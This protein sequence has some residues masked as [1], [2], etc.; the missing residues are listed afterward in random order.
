M[1]SFIGNRFLIPLFLHE[2]ENFKF[3]RC[4]KRDDLA[5][6]CFVMLQAG[7]IPQRGVAR[8]KWQPVSQR[9]LEKYIRRESLQST[10]SKL[11]ELG[12]IESDG[13]IQL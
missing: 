7:C 12:V 13:K 3:L 10:R 5:A 6:Y 1:D 2:A 9:K 4:C 11:V 8:R